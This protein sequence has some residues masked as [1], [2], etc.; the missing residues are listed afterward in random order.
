MPIA[1]VYQCLWAVTRDGG[2]LTEKNQFNSKP[3]NVESHLCCGQ[4]D[5]GEFGQVLNI[6]R[7]TLPLSVVKFL[8]LGHGF[9]QL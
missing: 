5:P 2:K 7:G 3:A 1:Q 4:K 9:D 6:H 8:F